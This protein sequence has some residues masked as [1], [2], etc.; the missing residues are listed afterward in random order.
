MS[1]ENDMWVHQ[2][3][4]TQQYVYLLIKWSVEKELN[5]FVLL[6]IL[7]SNIDSYNPFYY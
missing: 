4:I 7:I 6:E 3:G 5:M 1:A 2:I